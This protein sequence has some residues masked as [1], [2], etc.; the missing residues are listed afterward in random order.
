VL[1]PTPGFRVAGSRTFPRRG[2]SPSRGRSGE[3]GGGPASGVATIALTLR[4]EMVVHAEDPG[5]D[6]LAALSEEAEALARRMA[7]QPL[8][9]LTGTRREA[10]GLVGVR[11]V[12]ARVDQVWTR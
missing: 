1:R 7:A 10:P 6:A 12:G 3:P 5:R 2:R 8:R 4:V 11:G 9:T